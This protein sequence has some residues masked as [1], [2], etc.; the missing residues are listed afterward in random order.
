MQDPVELRKAINSQRRALSQ[1]S[2]AEAEHNLLEQAQALTALGHA[3][4]VL[5]YLPMNGEIS[6]L[7]LSASLQSAQIYLPRITDFS[8]SQMRFYSAKNPR[9][10]NSFGIEEPVAKG[11][12]IMPDSLDAVLMPLVACDPQGNRLG[13][14]GGYYDRA[15]A[16]RLDDTVSAL[17]LLVGVAHDFQ[18]VEQLQAAAWDV[19]LDAIITDRQFID[20]R[21]Q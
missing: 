10:R 3:K 18:L 12:S 4:T 20:L 19:P 13:M 6:P 11:C 21:K 9:Q 2:L 16:F 5:S 14:G 17:P 8:K 7:A 15:F 1:V